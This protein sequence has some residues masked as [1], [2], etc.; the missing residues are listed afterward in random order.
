M[1]VS[2]DIQPIPTDEAVKEVQKKLL[3][4]ETDITKW[5]QKQNMN[6]NFSATIPYE[7][8]QM[9][10]ERAKMAQNRKAF[11][12][13]MISLGLPYRKMKHRDRTAAGCVWVPDAFTVEE[14][15]L[16]E[17]KGSGEIPT[18][19]KIETTNTNNK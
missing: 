8:E 19:S 1:M 10:S 3:A 17:G 9:R 11:N 5:Q 13:R 12:D 4:I 18:M 14:A 16:Q 6:N 7:M 2:I 15:M